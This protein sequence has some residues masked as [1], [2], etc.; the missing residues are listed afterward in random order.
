MPPARSAAARLRIRRLDCGGVPRGSFDDAR[1]VFLTGNLNADSSD[2]QQTVVRMPPAKTSS[3]GP[4]ERPLLP[5][6]RALNVDPAAVEANLSPRMAPA[7]GSQACQDNAHDAPRQ[8]APHLRSSTRSGFR[9]LP[10]DRI[11]RNSPL[12][13]Q[14]NARS[15]RSP[16]PGGRNATLNQ[17][18]NRTW[19]IPL[20]PVKS[21]R[22]RA[23]IGLVHSVSE[24]TAWASPRASA[25]AP[26]HPG[27][28]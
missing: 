14:T 12:A 5:V 11:A 6:P 13:R 3:P 2:H 4:A 20:T 22:C 24:D 10:S 7:D 1:W 25:G 21:C 16:K 17:S 27:R 23:S 19:D 26:R 15:Q 28:R 18:F 9:C 8:A